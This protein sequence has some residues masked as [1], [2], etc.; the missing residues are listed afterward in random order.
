MSSFDPRGIYAVLAGL[1]PFLTLEGA[2]YDAPRPSAYDRECARAR[3]EGR[4]AAMA[5]AEA[6]RRR[7]RARPGGGA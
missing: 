2:P 3:R 5:A 6:K 4:D 7:R 1:E